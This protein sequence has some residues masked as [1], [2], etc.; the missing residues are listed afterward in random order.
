MKRVPMS[1]CFTQ[2]KCKD[3]T[4]GGIALAVGLIAVA[5]AVSEG[6]LT[7]ALSVVAGLCI[8]LMA[9]DA[10]KHLHARR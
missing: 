9:W 7:F 1:P 2:Q 4:L 8:G 5:A 3:A 10:W 6:W